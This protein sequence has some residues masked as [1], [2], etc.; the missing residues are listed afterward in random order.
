[1]TGVND[2]PVDSTSQLASLMGARVRDRRIASSLTQEAVGRVVGAS[3]AEIEAAETGERMLTPQEI[4]ELCYIL[5]VEP[6]W[7]F[8]G[9]L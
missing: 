4:V 9:L 6:S 5:R 1:M 7:F 2:L 8:E 3:V